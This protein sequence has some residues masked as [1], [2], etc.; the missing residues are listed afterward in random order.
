MASCGSRSSVP[1]VLLPTIASRARA[2]ERS[3]ARPAVCYLSKRDQ[4]VYD[5][6]RSD[7]TSLAK[8]DEACASKSQS[9]RELKRRRSSDPSLARYGAHGESS[10]QEPSSLL[11]LVFPSSECGQRLHLPISLSPAAQMLCRRHLGA[12]QARLVRRDTG[13]RPL[14]VRRAYPWRNL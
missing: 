2:L 13:C 8:C 7:S 5:P 14:R 10:R 1:G 3:S 11:S 12:A 4:S 9:S 6:A